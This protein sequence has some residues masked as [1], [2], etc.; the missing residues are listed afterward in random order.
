MSAEAAGIWFEGPTRPCSPCAETGRLDG[1]ECPVCAGLGF[2]PGERFGWAED[3]DAVLDD[4]GEA[5]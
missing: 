4:D 3:Y 2:V 1:E 5:L